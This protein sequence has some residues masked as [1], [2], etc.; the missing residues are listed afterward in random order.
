M[1]GMDGDRFT[2]LLWG[3]RHLLL[4]GTIPLCLFFPSHEATVAAA[5]G[6]EQS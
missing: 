5:Q 4:G 1:D 6:S 3:C 2:G